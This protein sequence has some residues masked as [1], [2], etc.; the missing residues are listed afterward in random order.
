MKSI[1]QKKN[2]LR[3]SNHNY[4]HRKNKM[5]INM[6]INNSG[7]SVLEKYRIVDRDHFVGMNN[8]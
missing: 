6:S 3:H 8:L 2:D 7:H 5:G 1:F 4:T